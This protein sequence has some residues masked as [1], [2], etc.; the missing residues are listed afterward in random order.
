M[1]R[2]C[3]RSCNLCA[4]GRPGE[5]RQECRGLNQPCWINAQCCSARCAVNTYHCR[6]VG[7]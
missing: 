2:Q 5:G 6:P 4:P 3:R 1:R 7:R